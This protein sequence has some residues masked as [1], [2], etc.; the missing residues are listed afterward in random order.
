MNVNLLITDNNF[1]VATGISSLQSKP[2]ASNQGAKFS[3]P[4]DDKYSQVNNLEKPTT[5][6]VSKEIQNEKEPVYES[7]NKLTQSI[8]QKTKSENTSKAENKTK[9]NEQSI[10]SDTIKQLSKQKN[11]VK[12]WLSENS[13]A[14]EHS[15]SI[16][17]ELSSSVT[18]EHSKAGAAI[19]IEPKAG[20]QLAQINTNA[21]V[22][23]PSSVTGNAVKSAEIKLLHATEKGQLGLK[24]ILPAKSNGENGLKDTLPNTFESTT[25]GKK[26]TETGNIDKVSILTRTI[27]E[28]KTATEKRSAT[29]SAPEIPTSTDKSTNISPVKQTVENIDL[30]IIQAKFQQVQPQPPGIDTERPAT[31]DQKDTKAN[32]SLKISNLS[33]PNSKETIHTG[34]DIPE[35]QSVQK[36]NSAAMQVSTNQI[37]DQSISTSDKTTPQSFEQ[38]LQHNHSEIPIT[39]QTSASTKSTTTTDLPSQESS[40]DVSADIGKQILES[41]QRTIS[42]QDAE[43]QI[44]IRLNP[45][46]LGKVLIKFQQ[47]DNELTGLME[48]SKN[49]TR[50]EIEQTLPQIIRNLVDS[51]VQIKRLEVMLSNEQQSG[52]GTSSNQ[53]LQSGGAQ[54]QY[55][56]NS[57]TPQNDENI[58]QSNEWLT[59][60][61]SY[62]NLSE[63]QEALITDGSINLL[64]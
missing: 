17:V 11:L 18:V 37:K 21:P 45:P 33:N 10:T 28:T 51:G 16:A 62:D 3:L 44:T 15:N 39:E 38:M 30:K 29:E 8:P 26:Q 6:N 22:G 20:Q 49:Q 14:I 43:Q 4:P 60:N 47:H 36:L 19:K 40:K 58:S 5:D 63:L 7:P 9:P 48:V 25:I 54:Q 46:E 32:A 13:V 12:S 24:T 61:N 59:G 1:P 2:D 64:I 42:Q 53:S 55:S 50:F 52:Q 41:V 56:S 35:N 31:T 27:T 34:N 57:G 23:K